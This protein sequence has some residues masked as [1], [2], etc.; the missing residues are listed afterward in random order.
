MK[1]KRLKVDYDYEFKLFGLISSVKG[2]KLTWALN[3][4]L[5]TELVKMDDIEFRKRDEK[6]YF[7]SGYEYNTP[8][9][10]YLLFK[11]RLT[12]TSGKDAGPLLP[13]LGQ[14]DYFLRVDGESY[15]NTPDVISK[16][17]KELSIVEYS[18]QVNIDKLKSKE[19]LLLY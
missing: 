11:N 15:P 6:L 8:N 7:V 5:K 4:S 1:P 16:K 14:I 18:L 2:F 3:N 19:N 17:L 10:K 9:S 13:E 12:D